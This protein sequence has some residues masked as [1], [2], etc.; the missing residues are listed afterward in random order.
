MGKPSAPTWG[1]LPGCTGPVWAAGPSQ[2]PAQRGFGEA[3]GPGRPTSCPPS[4]RP[5]TSVSARRRAGHARRSR[6]RLRPCRK[7]PPLPPPTSG[8]VSS[9]A[10][11]CARSGPLPPSPALPY[12]SEPPPPPP[13][14]GPSPHPGPARREGWGKGRR[15]PPPHSHPPGLSSTSS[16]RTR[17]RMLGCGVQPA[18]R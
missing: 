5:R 15:L 16:S 8:P 6:R 11:S 17:A 1:K 7:S 4:S 10:P 3:R 14:P 9:A 2:L 12:R 13:R 18:L